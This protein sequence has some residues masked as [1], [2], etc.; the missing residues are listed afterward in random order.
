MLVIEYRNGM[1]IATEDV[2]H[3]FKEFVPRI[4]RLS[5]FR[6]GIFAVFAD[7]QYCIDGHLAASATSNGNLFFNGKP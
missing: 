2:G 6:R 4:F 3:L 7:N 5:V 1:T